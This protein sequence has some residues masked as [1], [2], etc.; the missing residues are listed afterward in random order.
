M[1]DTSMT[2]TPDRIRMRL[3]AMLRELV[4][5]DEIEI[6]LP[7]TSSTAA[8]AFK[9][10]VDQHPELASWSGVVAF[11]IEDRVIGPNATIPPGTTIMD[12]LPP[13]SGG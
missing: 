5:T 1:S 4:G 7:A 12:V 3:H 9:V 8:A 6:R 11:A 2:D 10:L 13:V